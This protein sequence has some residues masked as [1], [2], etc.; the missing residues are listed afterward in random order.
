MEAA[1]RCSVKL[2]EGDV[3]GAVHLLCSAEKSVLPDAHSFESALLKIDFSNAL[4][5][6]AGIVYWR[7]SRLRYLN[8]FPFLIMIIMRHPFFNLVSSRCSLR[9]G[10]SKGTRSAL[11]YYLCGGLLNACEC[12]FGA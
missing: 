1:K 5:I 2:E 4:S 7:L 11:L 10:F 9:K 8:F 3:R 12:D 6:F